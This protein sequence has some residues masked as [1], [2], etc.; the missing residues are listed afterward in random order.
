[1]KHLIILFFLP[2]ISLAQTDTKEIEPRNKFI[3]E[4]GINIYSCI[5][6]QEDIYLNNLY[7]ENKTTLKAYKPVFEQHYLPGVFGKVKHK[8]NILRFSV[9]YIKNEYSEYD[10]YGDWYRAIDGISELFEY[11]LGYERE[12]GSTKLKPF[13]SSDFC[14]RYSK[15]SGMYSGQSVGSIPPTVSPTT[16]KNIAYAMS[17]GTGLKYSVTKHIYLTYELTLQMGVYEE[18]MNFDYYFI[19]FNPIRQLGVSYVF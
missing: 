13:V 4:L 14:Y 8:K 1:M 6:S 11:K 3:F 18:G 2:F 7:Q 9:D 15:F 5:D 17:I 16:E 12:F 10:H 19:H